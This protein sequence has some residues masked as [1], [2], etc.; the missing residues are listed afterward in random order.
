MNYNELILF[1]AFGDMNDI[2]KIVKLNNKA[3]EKLYSICDEQNSELL[4]EIKAS[5]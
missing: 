4:N 2:E 1:C 5:E 3:V